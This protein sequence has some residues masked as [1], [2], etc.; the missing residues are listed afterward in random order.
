MGSKNRFSVSIP[1]KY[2][3]LKVKGYLKGSL[4]KGRATV[5]KHSILL[6]GG[7]RYYCR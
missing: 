3:I 1:P 4:N 2:S 6:S 5:Q 7:L